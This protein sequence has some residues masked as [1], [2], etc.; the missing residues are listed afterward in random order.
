MKHCWILL[1]AL[2]GCAGPLGGLRVETPLKL[3][4]QRFTLRTHEE[5]LPADKEVI[6]TAITRATPKLERWGGLT[7]PV[8]VYVVKSHDDLEAA[9]RRSGFGWLRAWGRF[10]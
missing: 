1:C 9:V 5:S 3:G 2:V 7:E 4:E 8:T 10:E 6:S